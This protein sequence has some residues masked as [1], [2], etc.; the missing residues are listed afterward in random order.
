MK[1]LILKIIRKL[2]SLLS[3]SWNNDSIKEPSI[4]RTDLMYGYYGTYGDQ[5][6]EV[7]DHT[8]VLFLTNWEGEDKIISNMNS[9]DGS[10]ILDLDTWIFETKEGQDQKRYLRSDAHSNLVAYFNKLEGLG[11]L[12]KVKVLITVDEP[13]LM[14]YAITNNVLEQA[15][16]LVKTVATQFQSLSGVK[17]GVIYSREPDLDTVHL[18]DIIG[19]DNYD[20]GSE[21]LTTT[22]ED[23]IDEMF[24]GQQLWLIPGGS[25]GQDP[26]DFVNYSHNTSRVCGIIPFLWRYPNQGADIKGIVEL[27]GVKQKYIDAGKEL[28]GK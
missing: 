1:K 20:K 24:D 17:Y 23:F 15:V 21:I 25:Y 7:K 3:I 5:V 13:N 19:F 14:E 26:K 16:S 27:E 6:N 11:L 4:K 9:F 22:Y 8:N 18:F 2:M 12:S 10:F 28:T